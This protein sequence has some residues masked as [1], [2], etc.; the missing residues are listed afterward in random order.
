[1]SK[2]RIC[3]VTGTRAEYG[4]FVPVMEAIQRHRRLDLQVVVTGMHLLK[5]FGHT[6]KA[7]EADGWQIDARIPLQSEADDSLAQA[8]GMGRAITRMAETFTRLKTDIVLVLG[9]RIEAFAAAAAA[10]A[11]QR[12]IGHIHGGDAAPGVQDDAYRHAITKLAH[13]HF[14]ASD[15]ALT[16]ILRLGEE[17]FRTYQTGSPALDNIRKLLCQDHHVLSQAAGFDIRED[18]LLVVQHPA[19]GSA[20]QEA[21]RMKQTLSACRHKDINIIA[22]YPNTD[23]GF[24]GILH[25]LKAEHKAGHCHLLANVPRPI[26][27]G[28]L[29]KARA[30]VGNSSSGI[31]EA[32]LLNVDVINV[33]PRQSGRQRGHNVINT[34]YGI[35]PVGLALDRILRRR[36]VRSRRSDSVYGDGAAGKK[37]ADILARVTLNARLRQKRMAY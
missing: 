16:R 12:I 27:L 29:S 5:R 25:T 4:I 19:G 32:G 15:E 36:Q 21:L 23:P 9:D 18:F 28:L 30:L 26:Y 31:I 10:T 35:R 17:K 24:S 37:I 7:I 6:I 13:L 22:L 8:R 34:D 20:R 1:M 3:I 14:A 33:G 2:R 11:A